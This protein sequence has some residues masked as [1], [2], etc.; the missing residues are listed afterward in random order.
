MRIQKWLLKFSFLWLVVGGI[1][2]FAQSLGTGADE[3]DASDPA[4]M[5]SRFAIDAESYFFVGAARYYALR[6]GYEYGLQNQK[7]L[8][9][10]SLPMVHTIFNA[11]FGGYE[12]TTGVGDLKM[13]YMFVPYQVNNTSGLQRVSAYMEVTA[14]TGESALGRGAGTWVYRPG[15]IFTMRPNPYV[16]FYPEIKYQFSTQ[17]A[18]ILSGDAP[19][20]DDPDVDGLIKNLVMSLPVIAIVDNWKGW[21]G[22]NATYIQSFSEQT[23]YVFLRLDFGTMIGEKSSA[24]LNITKFIAGQPRLD[25][26]VQAKFQFFLR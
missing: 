6:F 5:K 2:T 20:G 26:L 15:M 11:D 4:T 22:M 24:A 10:M 23:Y 13:R 12:N 21:A 18:N 14:P 16:S 7:H 8:F 9:G 25:V 3:F 19:D 1:E 17:E